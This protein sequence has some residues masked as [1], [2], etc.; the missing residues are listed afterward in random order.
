[1]NHPQQASFAFAVSFSLVVRRGE[2]LRTVHQ[3][4][5]NA[6]WQIIAQTFNAINLIQSDLMQ[7]TDIIASFVQRG[8]IL[9]MEIGADTG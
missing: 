1:M 6:D 7:I 3:R 4:I 9:Q 2:H 5:T 8:C